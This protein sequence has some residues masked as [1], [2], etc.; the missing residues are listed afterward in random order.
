M[1]NN[2]ENC[3][4]LQLNEE[5]TIFFPFGSFR[6]LCHTL[7]THFMNILNFI[8]INITL[9]KKEEEKRESFHDSKNSFQSNQETMKKKVLAYGQNK[10]QRSGMHITVQ[11][12][13]YKNFESHKRTEGA[14]LVM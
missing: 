4:Y 2:S 13:M 14:H 7:L 3:N 5:F 9:R 12:C 11:Q 8:I 10:N 1:Y 6:Q